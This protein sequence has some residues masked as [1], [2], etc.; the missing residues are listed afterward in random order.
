MKE[1]TC[2]KKVSKQGRGKEV[3]EKLTDEELLALSGITMNKEEIKDL[4]TLL[5]DQEE[6]IESFFTEDMTLADIVTLLDKNI[7]RKQIV[8]LI[9]SEDPKKEIKKILD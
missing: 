5:R 9:T 2:M 7:S 8:Q 6:D 1:K 4:I 3:L